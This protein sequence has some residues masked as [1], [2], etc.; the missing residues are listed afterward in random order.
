M[1]LKPNNIG[2]CWKGLRINFHV[3]P[4]SSKSFY[5]WMSF[6]TFCNFLKIPSVLIELHVYWNRTSAVNILFS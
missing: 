2:S 3:V 4:L 1:R 6:I 5:F